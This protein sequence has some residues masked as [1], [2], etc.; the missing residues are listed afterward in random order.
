[1]ISFGRWKFVPFGGPDGGDGG[2]GGSVIVQADEGV[3]SLKRYKQ[4]RFYRADNGGDGQGKKKH[5]RSGEDLILAGPVG[6]VVSYNAPMADAPTADLDKAGQPAPVARRG[7]G[8]RRP[9]LT[10][11]FRPARARGRSTRLR[12]SYRRRGSSPRHRGVPGAG[13]RPRRA[14]YPR[15]ASS[16]RV[17]SHPHL[18]QWPSS[19]LPAPMW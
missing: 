3:T 15:D 16:A 12:G 2:D 18:Q 17:H 5:G 6:T 13:P 11:R 7:R 8:G 4:K 9:P 14:S 19:F 10:H 1:M